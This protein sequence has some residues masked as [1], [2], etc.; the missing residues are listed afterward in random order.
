[1]SDKTV[2]WLFPLYQEIGL[3]N[4]GDTGDGISSVQVKSFYDVLRMLGE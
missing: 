4:A 2:T 1:M 3:G